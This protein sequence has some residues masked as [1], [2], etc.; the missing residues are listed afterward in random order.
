M[1]TGV[2]MRSSQAGPRKSTSPAAH[3]A[4]IAAE[5]PRFF[6]WRPGR[7]DIATP[8]TE[9]TVAAQALYLEGDRFQ[10]SRLAPVD[11]E[12][13]VTGGGTGRT[14]RAEGS[15]SPKPLRLV[16]RVLLVVEVAGAL[17]VGWLVLQYLYT[18]YFDT[19]PRRVSHPLPAGTGGQT[20]GGVAYPTSSPT[21]FVE[22]AP[23]LAGG[24]GSGE[25]IATVTPTPT[26]PLEMRLPARLR[27]PAM[28]LD[29][30]VHEVTVN[31]GTWEVSPMD[32]GHH[33][34]T[35]NPGEVGNVVLAGHRDINSALFRELD[36]L[37]PGDE[38]FVSNSLG[39][40][41]YVVKES[42]VVS[43]D[44]TEVMEPTDDSRVTLI[45]C[46]PIGLATQRLIVTAML[47][48]PVSTK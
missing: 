19:A 14:S 12:G 6:R 45:T 28:F 38:V 22:V 25:G 30:Q 17:V 34:G 18:V 44:H 16:D 43:P 8:S 23:P 41:R 10:P 37:E 24:P 33:T 31:M 15:L 2:S 35:G 27:I 36:R 46:T 13:V 26:V 21:R 40:Y 48:G 5:R 9:K 1:Q 42:M 32:I 47:S 29:S 20:Q 11:L 7:S 39:E 4:A 3:S